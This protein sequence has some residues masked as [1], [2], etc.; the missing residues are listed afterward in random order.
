MATRTL[1][2]RPPALCGLDRKR[3][4]T[5]LRVQTKR[6]AFSCDRCSF[7]QTA[8]FP[9]GFDELGEV[10][11]GRP[12]DLGQRFL[13]RRGDPEERQP[14]F[15]ERGHRDLVG[16]VERAWIGAALLPGPACQ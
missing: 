11:R 10:P 2:T 5:T 8:R 6:V 1:T 4:A 3:P 15:E 14:A 9:V 16:G 12:V 13:D 7:G